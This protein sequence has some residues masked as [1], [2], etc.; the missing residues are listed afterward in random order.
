MSDVDSNAVAGPSQSYELQDIPPRANEAVF[1]SRWHPRLT[2]YRLLVISLTAGFGLAKAILTYLG[3]SLGS[4]TLE[5]VFAVVICLFLY[6]LGL[7]E[8]HAPLSAPWLFEKDYMFVCWQL[9]H[10]FKWSI[11]TYRSDERSIGMLIKPPHPSVT[12]YRILLILITTA[13]GSVKAILS[14]QGHTTSP[15]TLDWVFG[16]VIIIG[17]YWLGL[18]QMSTV[19]VLPALFDTDY[20]PV[21]QRFLLL[22]FAGGFQLGYVLIHIVGMVL[23]TGWGYIWLHGLI[24][25]WSAKTSGEGKD[26]SSSPSTVPPSKYDVIAEWFFKVMWSAGACGAIGAAAVGI[27]FL[28]VHLFVVL[29][30][31][32]SA[33]VRYVRRWRGVDERDPDEERGLLA[34]AQDAMPQ[35]PISLGKHQPVLQTIGRYVFK[36][37]LAIGYIVGHAV[38]FI[39]A[40][41][42]TLLW[43]TGL[44]G[45]WS[46]TV[47]SSDDSIFYTAFFWSF[48][49]LWSAGACAALGIGSAGCLAVLASL[50]SP[51]TGFGKFYR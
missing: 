15:N 2:L 20:T 39:L 8:T 18:Y 26:E 13:F 37:L 38:A 12:G 10:A 32:L 23:A 3:Q 44:R 17:M 24:D 27:G 34:W 19:Q 22:S 14:Y 16:V 43:L 4:T 42:W 45:I 33:I 51:I 46:G 21:I 35:Q 31:A 25:L 29:Q 50:I 49:L 11:P 5:W 7:F 1:T 41:G 47:T 6:F 28:L 9:L 36:G 48:R 40:L 30:P